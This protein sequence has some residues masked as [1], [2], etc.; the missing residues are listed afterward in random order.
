MVARVRTMTTDE[1]QRTHSR[2]ICYLC[3][4]VG[5]LSRSCN[6]D[7]IKQAYQLL[8]N[9]HNLTHAERSRVWK[10]EYAESVK[11]RIDSGP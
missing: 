1:Y 6:I 3:Y 10:R 7:P 11:E 9:W 5:H 8:R 2:L 4:A